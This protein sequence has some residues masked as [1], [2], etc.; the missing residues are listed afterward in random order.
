MN[1]KLLLVF[2][3][4]VLIFVG[5][6]YWQAI[7]Q[8]NQGDQGN[9]EPRIAVEPKEFDFGEVEF[10]KVV[11]QAFTIKNTGNGL[12][13]I[14]RVSTSCA[15]TKAK[16][17][18]EKLGPDEEAELLVTYDAGAMGRKIIGKKLERFI[19]IKSNDPKNPQVEVV[20]KA[21]VK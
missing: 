17:D 21:T 18:K 12:L 19:F 13:E 9:L 1:S 15:C 5:Y 3:L 7:D 11:K 14:K 6:G 8:K 16:I 20:I 10:G 2:G 4:V